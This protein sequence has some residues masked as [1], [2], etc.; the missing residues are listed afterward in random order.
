MKSPIL[1]PTQEM[2]GLGA[3]GI[4]KDI[5]FPHVHPTPTP[6]ARSHKLW[7]PT[8]T[9]D[10][11]TVEFSHRLDAFESCHQFIVTFQLNHCL[12]GIEERNCEEGSARG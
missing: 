12:Q 4:S 1:P 9:G 10:Y 6:S 11:V 7:A 5:G 2:G 3:M 8:Y